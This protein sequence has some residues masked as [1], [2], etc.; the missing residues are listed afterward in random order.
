MR[1]AAEY[2]GFLPHNQWVAAVPEVGFFSDL[3]RVRLHA[4]AAHQFATQIFADRT[5]YKAEASLS[6]SKN[7]NLV[8]EYDVE[9][10]RHGHNR[11]VLQTTLQ[12][13]F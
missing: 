6:L 7:V 13:M 1:G 2:G 11:T 9:R 3:G 12:F 5:Q 4:S 8:A 10:N